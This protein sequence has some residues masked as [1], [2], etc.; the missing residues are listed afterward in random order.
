MKKIITILS[1]FI[2]VGCSFDKSL[3]SEKRILDIIPSEG[4]G[5]YQLGMT[6]DELINIL[7]SEYD[8]QQSS[9][10]FSNR[11]TTFY[12]IENMSFIFRDNNLKEIRVYGSFRGNFSDIDLEFNKDQ[13]EN[14]G[15]VIEH[16]GE[17]RILDIPNIAFGIE[18]EDEKK[19]I[20]I[21]Q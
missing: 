8:K 9:A 1:L 14:Y 13:L 21:Y 5:P 3:C 12:F 19:Y 7:C 20:R 18:G 6:E 15:D 4:I 2:F 10:W 11:K 17:Y 16:E